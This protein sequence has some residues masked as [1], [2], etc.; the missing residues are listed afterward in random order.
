MNTHY[1]LELKTT[2]ISGYN[3]PFLAS[4]DGKRI[5]EIPIKGIIANSVPTSE[6]GKKRLIDWKRLVASEV[7]NTRKFEN[8]NSND[9][10]VISIGLQFC[11]SYHGNQKLDLDNFIKPLLDSIAA[12]LFCKPED[13]PLKFNRF[14][15]DDSNFKYLFVYRL[16]D[17]KDEKEEGVIVFVYRL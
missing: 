12:G 8:V 16:P 4:E 15:Y 6:I 10:F 14:D 17:T 1:N 11:H 9:I 7:K 5:V 3:I 13:N 2:N